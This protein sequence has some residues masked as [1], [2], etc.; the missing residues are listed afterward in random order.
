MAKTLPPSSMAYWTEGKLKRKIQ[1]YSAEASFYDDLNANTLSAS[2]GLTVGGETILSNSM[3]LSGTLSGAATGMTVLG[4]AVFSNAVNISGSTTLGE[5]LYIGRYIYHKGNTTTN[6]DF[7]SNEIEINCGDVKFL[8]M[9]EAGTDIFYVDPAST[10]IEFRVN[11]SNG[12]TIDTT[13]AGCVI[14]EIGHASNDF[15]VESNSNTH[16]LFVDAG[17]DNVGIGTA[18]PE[19]YLDIKNVVDDGTTNRTMLRL[20]NYRPDDADVND[21]GPISIDFDIENVGGGAKTGTARIAAV[22]SPVG[23]DHATILG[24]KTSALIF[25]T[26]NDDTLAEAMRINASGNIGIGTTSP[27]N[28]VQIDHTGADGDDGLMIV[29]AD[30]TT[31]AD[32]LLGGIGFDS[33]D[34]NVPSAI[35]EASAYLAGYASQNHSATEKGGYLVFGTALTN[36]NDDTTSNEV[37]RV[38]ADGK[39]SINYAGDTAEATGTPSLDLYVFSNTA[40]DAASLRFL[41]ADNTQASPA[42]TDTSDDIGTVEW[43][44]YNAT[45]TQYD[46]I[47]DIFVEQVG[48]KGDGD[49]AGA[50]MF[51]R[52][53]DDSGTG[54][55]NVAKFGYDKAVTLY[56]PATIPGTT[57]AGALILDGDGAVVNINGGSNYSDRIAPFKIAA[58]DDT[59]LMI[60]TNQIECSDNGSLYAQYN[61]TGKLYLVFGGGETLIGTVTDNGAYKLQVNSQIYA[62]NATI[63]TSDQKFKTDVTPLDGALDIVRNLKPCT[64]NFIPHEEKS[65]D[66][67]RLQVGFVAQE[68]EAALSD[69]PYKDSIVHLVTERRENEQGEVEVVGEHLALAYTKLL[70]ILTK[71]IQEQQEEIKDQKNKISQLEE[72]IEV[73][74]DK[75]KNQ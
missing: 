37:M 44:S 17:E 1:I 59:A 22:S 11:T 72:K 33:T 56:G 64:F 53:A 9:K 12:A 43:H 21:F 66:L 63:A 62:T 10:G 5:D 40:T 32:D 20:H 35:T 38:G 51:L 42:D 49:A 50:A 58:A 4:N 67:D 69:A 65:F 16:M 31:V 24:E 2:H 68:V 74:L 26:M 25:S 15:R 8:E 6:I 7:Q 73:L 28:T 13:A 57:A 34:G 54:V 41:K 39:V 29:R 75:E 18:A 3:K 14:N 70:P 52:C 27:M 60:D 48:A 19:A 36:E 23:T 45:N 47:A 61:S 55:H 30:S 71:A 46:K